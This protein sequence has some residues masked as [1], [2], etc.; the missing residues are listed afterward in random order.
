M[1]FKPV[2]PISI[3]Y[4]VFLIMFSVSCFSESKNTNPRGMKF[5]YIKPGTFMM[6][7]PANDPERYYDEKQHRVTLTKGFLLQTTEVTQSQWE[8]V[9][10]KNPSKFKGCGKCPVERV[11]WRNVREF[12]R[13]LNQREG[14]DKYRL[15]TEA[16]WEYAA[17]AGTTSP[18]AFGTCLSTDQANYKGNYPMPGCSKGQYR[19]KTVPVASFAPNAWGLYDMHGNVWEWVQDWY[20]DYYDGSV[21][22]PTGPATGTYRVIRGGSWYHFA[23]GCRSA[24]RVYDTPYYRYSYIGFRLAKD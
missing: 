18:F 22:D 21:T 12:I 23:R 15:P 8:A 1:K 7:S 24:Y 11:S 10:G 14:T 13:K 5:V 2:V 6:G 9:M 16:E 19:K 3:L 17:R 4:S 20:H